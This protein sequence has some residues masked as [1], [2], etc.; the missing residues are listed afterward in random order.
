MR[1]LPSLI[2]PSTGGWIDLQTQFLNPRGQSRREKMVRKKGTVQPSSGTLATLQ[3]H[4]STTVK[5]SNLKKKLQAK[6]RKHSM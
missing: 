3:G 1:P 2:L 4:I 5:Y 6:D